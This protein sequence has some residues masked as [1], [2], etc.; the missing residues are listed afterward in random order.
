MNRFFDVLTLQK[1]FSKILLDLTTAVLQIVFGLMLL[2]FYHAS[3]VFFG[4]FLLVVL[5]LIFRL[6]GPKALKTSLKE[7]KYKYAMVAW[8]EDL[9]SNI[10]TFKMAGYSTLPMDKTDEHVDAY[11][12]ARKNHFKALLSHF[13]SI[14]AFKLFIAN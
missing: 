12:K 9:A 5:T 11:L 7:S 6:S 10:K 1:S 4:M 2:A 8:F 13:I 14:T 3:F